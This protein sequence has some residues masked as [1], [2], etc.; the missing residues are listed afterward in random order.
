MK[1]PADSTE[2]VDADRTTA[3]LKPAEARSRYT[4][5]VHARRRP[6]KRWSGP[7]PNLG[8]GR[9]SVA[10]S[11][12][13]ASRP[14]SAYSRSSARRRRRQR[15]RPSQTEHPAP[16]HA[17]LAVGRTRKRVLHGPELNSDDCKVANSIVRPATSPPSKAIVSGGADGCC[18]WAKPGAAGVCSI[19]SVEKATTWRCICTLW[20]TAP[21]ESPSA[22]SP[23]RAGVSLTR[24][25]LLPDVVRCGSAFDVRADSR[26]GWECEIDARRADP[27]VVAHC[28]KH[29]R[30]ADC[31]AVGSDRDLCF[32]PSRRLLAAQ[33]MPALR[34]GGRDGPRLLLHAGQA[35][36]GA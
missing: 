27:R 20:K 17:A 32:E 34:A 31:C 11:R 33:I 28:N 7:E 8:A 5:A 3:A 24:R 36:A 12:E 13:G 2:R 9:M 35:A 30:A 21:A 6:M 22:A 4:P 18:L 19:A 10:L 23:G 14:R 1:A 15:I 16:Q 25:R 29:A 26:S